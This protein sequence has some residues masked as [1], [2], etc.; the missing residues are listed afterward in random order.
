MMVLGVG[1]AFWIAGVYG[2]HSHQKMQV[3]EYQA[4]DQ[5]KWRFDEST[6]ITV[7][8]FIPENGV[9]YVGSLKKGNPDEAQKLLYVIGPFPYS[10]GYNH[11]DLGLIVFDRA[12]WILPDVWDK[13]F[14]FKPGGE[15]WWNGVPVVHPNTEGVVLHV[16]GWEDYMGKHIPVCQVADSTFHY[17]HGMGLA[18]PEQ[19]QVSGED[20]EEAKSMVLKGENIEL[21]LALKDTE[22]HLDKVLTE[23]VNQEK[24]YRLRMADSKRRHGDIMRTDEP[25]K[26]RLVN[27]KTFGIILVAIIVLALMYNFLWR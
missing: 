16:K 15:V 19:F 12:Y 10:I 4:F 3:A 21:R 14:F 20:V 27:M 22:A 1:M 11:P 2:F 24:M 8:L 25:L 13:T 7:D 18:N 9:R 5:S 23:S 26:Y 6:T 17:K